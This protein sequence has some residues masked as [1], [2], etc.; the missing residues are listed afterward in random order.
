V[1]GEAP[2][3]A[4]RRE[5]SPATARSGEAVA[6][7]PRRTSA[8]GS[9]CS[10]ERTTAELVDRVGRRGGDGGRGYVGGAGAAASAMARR[11]EGESRGESEVSAGSGRRR[12]ARPGVKGRGRQA[13]GA[14]ASPR[15]PASPPCLPG[16]D[17]AAG[18]HGPAQCW[19]ARW[20]GWWLCQISSFSFIFYFLYFCKFVAFL[21]IPRHFQKSPNCSCPLYRVY[22]IWNISVWDYLDI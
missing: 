15:T 19:A 22:P 6:V 5:G 10:M 16:E 9:V 18:W 4:E 3:R 20:A 21:K 11:G 14:V 7:A 1:L 13:A 12:G 17:E 8:R 2:E